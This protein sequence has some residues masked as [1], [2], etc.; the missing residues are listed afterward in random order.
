MK[1]R[2][3]FTICLVALAI[4]TVACGAQKAS[5]DASR[6]GSGE[7]KSGTDS[8]AS[9]LDFAGPQAGR[10]EASRDSE[11]LGDKAA[12]AGTATAPAPA[13]DLPPVGAKIV[14]NADIE[15]RVGKGAFSSK[16]TKISTIAEEFG[17]FVA[18]SSTSTG[19]GK[20]PTSGSITIRVPADRFEAAIAKVKGLGTVKSESQSGE[21][22][23]KQFVDLEARLTQAKAQEAFF[24]RLMDQSKSISDLIQVQSQLSQVQ[25]QI[26]QLKGDLQFLKDQTT[27]STLSVEMFE[28]GAAVGHPPIGLSK[29]W[30][31]ATVGFRNVVGGFVVMAGW[32]APFVL[33]GLLGLGGFRLSRRWRLRQK[34][35][36][37]PA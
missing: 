8:S 31:E 28:P 34:P 19:S 16:F 11:P 29:A 24:L 27:Y 26:E 37:T 4:G 14:K 22:V 15:V 9:H 1:S 21:D 6:T 20:K 18:R 12:G 35:S 3:W 7:L 5:F 17:G 23:T 25:L 30:H 13:I 36:S 32:A 33:A 10:V 2:M